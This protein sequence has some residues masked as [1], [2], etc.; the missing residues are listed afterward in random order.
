MND[1]GG[2]GTR[3]RIQ[4]VA[5][6]LFTEQG[7]EK[8]SLREIAGQLG[9]TKAAL[10]Y[11]FKS[12]EELV[13]SFLG[14]R[15]AELDAQV[16]WLREQPRTPEVRREFIRRYADSMHATQ[17]RDLLRFFENNQA[18]LKDMSVGLTMRERMR[19]L[20][21]ALVDRSAPLPAQLRVALGVWALHTSSFILD[22]DIPEDQRHAAATEVALDLVS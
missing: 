13:E 11:H 20:L 6:K 17:H 16:A 10:Y 9:V 3:E 5:L 4:R 1:T 7:Y 21:A 19:D 2:A 12:K 8:T 18:A 14:D 15:L 22:P